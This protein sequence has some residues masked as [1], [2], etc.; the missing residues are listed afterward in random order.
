[1][2]YGIYHLV[3]NA[4]RKFGSNEYYYA[5][6]LRPAEMPSDILDWPYLQNDPFLFTHD[7]LMK[8][9]ERARKNPED[10][11]PLI[12]QHKPWWRRLFSWGWL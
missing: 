6:R 5:V 7:E 10:I 11:E 2:S 1:M 8:A 9:S 12:P 4:G 3:K